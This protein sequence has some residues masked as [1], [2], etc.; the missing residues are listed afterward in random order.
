[1][2]CTLDPSPRWAKTRAFGKTPASKVEFKLSPYSKRLALTHLSGADILKSRSLVATKLQLFHVRISIAPSLHHH[3]PRG[4][5]SR[6]YRRHHARLSQQDPASRL[7]QIG[8]RRPRSRLR[9]QYRSCHRA[10]PPA[11]E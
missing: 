11:T 1:R 5:R 7:A 3:A 2:R 8:L 10:L 9:R 4:R 6:P